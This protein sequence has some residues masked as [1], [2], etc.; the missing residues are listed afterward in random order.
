MKKKLK[1]FGIV[2]LILLGLLLSLPWFLSK[3]VPQGSPGP[4]ADGLA[5]KMLNALNDTIYEQTRFLKWSYRGG[6]N[7]YLWDKEMGVVWM[8]WQEQRA[9]LF[10]SN[11]SKSKAWKNGKSL[12]G[13]EK[14]EVVET[15][16]DLFNNDSFWLVAPY[17]VFDPGTERRLVEWEGEKA[18]LVTYRTGGSTPGD[19]YLWLLNDNG[20]PR[21]YLMWVNILPI[22]GLEASWD[23]WLVTQTGTFLPK[24]HKIGPVTLGMGPVESYSKKEDI[25]ALYW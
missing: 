14:K 9:K 7:R 23:D 5:I 3:P 4:Q 11:P 22:G 2:L 21:A 1:L 19:S 12:E 8:Q 20:Y 15:A 25:P 6:E 17:K 24:S 10:L 18:L 13:D 16:T